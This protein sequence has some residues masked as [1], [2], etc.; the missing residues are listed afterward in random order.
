M[1]NKLTVVDEP[2][3]G[4]LILSDNSVLVYKWPYVHVVCN[5]QTEDNINKVREALMK[6][7]GLTHEHQIKMEASQWKYYY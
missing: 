2:V 4:I 1:K 5:H 7:W 6:Y 3:P